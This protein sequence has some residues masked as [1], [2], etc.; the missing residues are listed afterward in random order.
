LLKKMTFAGV[1][2]EIPVKSR[3]DSLTTIYNPTAAL[4]PSGAL[5]DLP[6]DL[7]ATAIPG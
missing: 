6:S 1:P 7:P 5:K 2:S 4:N 3:Q